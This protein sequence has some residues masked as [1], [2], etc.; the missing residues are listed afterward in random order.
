MPYFHK[1]RRPLPSGSQTRALRGEVEID[2]SYFGSIGR[3]NE[4]V[5][6]PA[7]Q[8]CPGFSRTAVRCTTAVLGDLKRATLLPIIR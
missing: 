5:E 4:A 1:F 3:G 2:E 6:R 7:R 8:L